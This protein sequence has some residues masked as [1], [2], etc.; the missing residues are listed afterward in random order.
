[1]AVLGAYTH[2]AEKRL[3]VSLRLSA[4]PHGTTRLPL[5]GVFVEIDIWGFFQNL[6]KKIKY[7]LLSGKNN[8]YFTRIPV[9]IYDNIQLSYS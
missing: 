7:S 2:T 4:L 6:S 5:E 1:M 9:Y 8:G 3:L